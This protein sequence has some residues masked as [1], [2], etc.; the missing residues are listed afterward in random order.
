MIEITTLGDLKIHINGEEI[1]EK[2]A[3]T[4]KLW[5]LLSLL[6][7]NRN[8]PLRSKV[9]FE[10][11]WQEDE[12]GVSEKAL[13][14]LIYRLRK[15][16]TYDGAPEFVQFKGNGYLLKNDENLVV[17]IHLLEDYFEEIRRPGLTQERKVGLLKK[18]I[19]VYNGEYI[20]DD[21]DMR[22]ANAV[23]RYE[24]IF[25]KLVSEL[26][27][28]YIEVGAHDELT[29]L[30]DKGIL[31]HPLEGSFYEHLA[32][33]LRDKGWISQAIAVCE[34]YFDILKRHLD[35]PA[36]DLLSTMHE[37]MISMERN[38]IQLQHGVGRALKELRETEQIDRALFCSLEVLKELFR[39]EKRKSSRSGSKLSI[40]L[41]SISNDY[42]DLPEEKALD[43]VK[44]CLRECC[45]LALRK[46]DVIAEYSKSQL[47][48][49]IT[50]ANEKGAETVVLRIRER[51]R[52]RNKNKGN[53]I[54]CEFKSSVENLI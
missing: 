17:D 9:I 36:S 51:F 5:K 13:Q 32:T 35:A 23:T 49:M 27:E 20:F 54:L 2:H 6:L 7:L 16:L 19:D 25:V 47:I 46:G 18:A 40:I 8:K 11:V 43:E 48:V 41:I 15:L 1:S 10:S 38:T 52:E 34:N 39:Y 3:K 44:R 50:G 22:I 26:A 29:K 28:H 45:M 53:K 31:L 24:S 21:D 30:C 33:S 37:Q 12:L 14:N 4:T 42:D